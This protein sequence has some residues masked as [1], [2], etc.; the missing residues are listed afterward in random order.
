M[1]RHLSVLLLLFLLAGSS[2]SETAPEPSPAPSD[3][4]GPVSEQPAEPDVYP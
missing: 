4:A 3:D 2:C 1:K